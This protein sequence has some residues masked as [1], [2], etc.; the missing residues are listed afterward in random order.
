MV[1]TADNAAE[2]FVR[3]VALS[4]AVT[5]IASLA[6]RFALHA[7]R[8]ACAANRYLAWLSLAALCAAL[9]L[10]GFAG[11]FAHRHPDFKTSATAAP[12]ESV[13]IAHALNAIDDV[14]P[15]SRVLAVVWA[16]GSLILLLRLGAR[17]RAALALKRG[18]PYRPSTPA[19]RRANVWFSDAVG[20]PVA[21]GYLRPAILLP[22]HLAANEFESMREH[23]LAHENAHLRRYDDFTALLYQ[24]CVAFAWWNPI[25]WVISPSLSAEREKACDDAVVLQTR[26]AKAYGLSLISL[27]RGNRFARPDHVLAL[28]EA[29]ERLADRIE[30]IVTARPRSVH[31]RIGT[32][33]CCALLA[34]LLGGIAVSLIPGFALCAR[35]QMMTSGA[36]LIRSTQYVAQIPREESVLTLNFIAYAPPKT[37]KPALH[38]QTGAKAHRRCPLSGRHRG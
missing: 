12:T 14:L 13:A 36:P 22:G 21:I 31:P 4:I 6:L 11:A 15:V 33:L 10:F 35:A 19:A 20:S 24:I 2:V 17:L 30:S 16:G 37:E 34:T 27:C 28:F 9:P 8:S 3:V 29:R 5:A 26:E 23:A 1:F 38:K 18:T 32:T 7:W 25:V